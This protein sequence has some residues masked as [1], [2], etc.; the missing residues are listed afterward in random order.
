MS[1]SAVGRKAASSSRE[2]N[3]LDI[4]IAHVQDLVLRDPGGLHAQVHDARVGLDGEALP[5]AQDGHPV[6]LPEEMAD[7]G[8]RPRLVL[9]GRDGDPDAPGGDALQEVQDAGVGVRAVAEMDSIMGQE[10]FPHPVD[11][12]RRV[13]ACGHRAL[14]QVRD[15]AADQLVV[16]VLPPLGEA[17]GAQGM[18][19]GVPQVLDRV[20]QGSVQVKN[21]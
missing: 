6:E 3:P 1:T 18:V 9:V 2:R 10:Q 5:L 13:A 19:R 7:D 8:L 15:A 20:E 14:E 4:G 16:F 11:G 12:F 17:E 21:H